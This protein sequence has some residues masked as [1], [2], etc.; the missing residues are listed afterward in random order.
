[1]ILLVN[2]INYYGYFGVQ[3]RQLSHAEAGASALH[4]KPNNQF[5]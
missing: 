1:M 2:Q 4:I 3:K 5:M